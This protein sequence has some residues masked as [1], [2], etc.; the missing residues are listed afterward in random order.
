[1]R[2]LFRAE[3][4]LY[5]FILV[6]TVNDSSTICYVIEIINLIV[7]GSGNFLFY[8]AMI[9]DVPLTF[10]FF[11]YFWMSQRDSL[12]FIKI[13]VYRLISAQWEISSVQFWRKKEEKKKTR[14]RAGKKVK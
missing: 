13:S 14:R 12:Y 10:L 4:D 11:K 9:C 7:K 6:S 5:R 8:V 3:C 2:I 1:M